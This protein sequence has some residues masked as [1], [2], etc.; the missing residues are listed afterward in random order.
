MRDD[1]RLADAKAKDIL[2]FARDKLGAKLKK[3]SAVEWAGSCPNCGGT[4]RFAINAK[5][6]VFICR[7]SG[8]GGDI[9]AMV[10]HVRGLDFDG[11][12]EFITGRARQ[13]RITSKSRIEIEPKDET[14]KRLGRSPDSGDAVVMVFWPGER[15]HRKRRMVA[16]GRLPPS[17]A[18]LG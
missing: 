17:V 4:D 14:K 13:K 16:A 2:L 3:A 5:D 1:P 6:G 8:A 7:G 11:A 18:D 10:E 9:V 15:A 12:L